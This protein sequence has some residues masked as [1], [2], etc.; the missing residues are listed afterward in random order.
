MN[1][2]YEQKSAMNFIGFFTSILE[3]SVD[4]FTICDEKR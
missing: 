1:V 2:T 4:L 3:N